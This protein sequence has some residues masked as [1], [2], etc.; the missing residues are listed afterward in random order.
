MLEGSKM[1]DHIIVD[2]KTYFEESYLQLA[3]AN[4][5]R[6]S[7]TFEDLMVGGYTHYRSINPPEAS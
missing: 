3:N 2:G 5:Q 6:A 7:S 1:S 4:A